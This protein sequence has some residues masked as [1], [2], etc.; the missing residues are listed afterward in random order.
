M[1]LCEGCSFA[2]ISFESAQFMY[3]L[4]LLLWDLIEDDLKFGLSSFLHPFFYSI[5]A[6]IP[7]IVTCNV[8]MLPYDACMT[9]LLSSS[10]VL[11]SFSTS[12]CLWV[13]SRSISCTKSAVVLSLSVEGNS[14]FFLSCS[15]M[16]ALFAIIFLLCVIWFLHVCSGV[17]ASPAFRKLVLAFVLSF[18]LFLILH[19]SFTVISWSATIVVFL[20]EVVEDSF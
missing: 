10:M 12:I 11:S 1:L 3:I 16:A 8:V 20:Q 14:C 15:C 13:C 2:L 7:T 17:I 19:S 18:S 6:S 5:S 9:V 4:G